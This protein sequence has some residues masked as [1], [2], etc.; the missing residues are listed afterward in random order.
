MCSQLVRDTVALEARKKNLGKVVERVVGN[1][2]LLI[3]LRWKFFLDRYLLV[4]GSSGISVYRLDERKSLELFYSL[5][6][7]KG[8]GPA[9]KGYHRLGSNW[10]ASYLPKLPIDIFWSNTCPRPHSLNPLRVLASMYH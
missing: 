2:Y 4:T 10:K 9:T 3:Y 1:S 7:V 6:G 8:T 5:P